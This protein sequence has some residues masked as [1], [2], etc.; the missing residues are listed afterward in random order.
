M[1]QDDVEVRTD[2]TEND[3]E[4]YRLTPKGIAM[5][6]LMDVGLLDDV[7]DKRFDLFWRL[8]EADMLRLGYVE[9]E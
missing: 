3:E 4:V 9:Y 8:F 2:E 6:C 1:G 5:V 7:D